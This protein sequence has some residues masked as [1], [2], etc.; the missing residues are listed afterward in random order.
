MLKF[1]PSNKIDELVSG[2]VLDLS[3]TDYI[4]QKKGRK[5][6]LI[7]LYDS[8]YNRIVFTLLTK[9]LACYVRVT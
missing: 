8:D 2:F 1:G 9:F 5:K 4:L 6:N 3:T 7:R